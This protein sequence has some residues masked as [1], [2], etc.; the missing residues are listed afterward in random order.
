M[1]MERDLPTNMMCHKR[2]GYRREFL[3]TLKDKQ[4]D[5]GIT[6]LIASERDSEEL[7]KMWLQ[8]TISW[9]YAFEAQTEEELDREYKPTLGV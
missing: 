4:G 6:R 3:P 8:T 1:T 7:F 2:P 5:L 9:L